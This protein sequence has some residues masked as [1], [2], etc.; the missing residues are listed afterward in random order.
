MKSDD[1]SNLR[2][3]LADASSLL[4]MRFKGSEYFQASLNLSR[5][6]RWL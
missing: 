2:S 4:P 6:F 3:R 1:L 5:F